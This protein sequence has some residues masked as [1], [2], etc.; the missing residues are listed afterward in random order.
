[1]RQ[2]LE[3]NILPTLVRQYLFFEYILYECILAMRGSRRDSSVLRGDR[4]LLIG[5]D[6]KVLGLLIRDDEIARSIS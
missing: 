6:R 3:V 2:L 1:M 4:R 5:R